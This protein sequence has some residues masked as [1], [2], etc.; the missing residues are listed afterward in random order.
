MHLWK[1]LKD[2]FQLETHCYVII[3]RMI[4]IA[5]LG[6][7]HENQLKAAGVVAHDY[8]WEIINSLEP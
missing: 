6:K 7:F 5:L 2:S 3:F 8:H 4:M 1:T